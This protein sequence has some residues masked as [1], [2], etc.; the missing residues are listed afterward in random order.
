MCNKLLQ[1]SGRGKTKTNSGSQDMILYCI[2]VKHTCSKF[3][4]LEIEIDSALHSAGRC[5]EVRF[6]NMMIEMVRLDP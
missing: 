4:E 2:T 5:W 6:D 3:E 1:S